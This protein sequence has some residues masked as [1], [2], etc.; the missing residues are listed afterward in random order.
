MIGHCNYILI[1]SEDTKTQEENLHVQ[2]CI[3]FRENVEDYF[4]HH[5]EPWQNSS[6]CQAT[7]TPLRSLATAWGLPSTVSIVT[8]E[9]FVVKVG[10]NFANSF[11][12]P[13]PVALFTDTLTVLQIIH[14][15]CPHTH[16][17]LLIQLTSPST[18][19]G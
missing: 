15:H 6:G 3:L 1:T 4:L 17:H 8:A 13:C 14:S 16:H 7:V 19:S 2:N 18:F 5:N 9:V 10:R 11:A 12:F